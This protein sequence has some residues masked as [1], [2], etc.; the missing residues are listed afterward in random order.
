MVQVL[1]NELE[2][3]RKSND[4]KDQILATVFH[5]FKTPINGICAIVESLEEKSELSS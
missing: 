3:S 2:E 5:D 1:T 4:N